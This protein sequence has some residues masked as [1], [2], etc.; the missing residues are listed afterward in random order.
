MIVVH[1]RGDRAATH[2]GA[3]VAALCAMLAAAAAP[4]AAQTDYY[5]TDAGRPVLI[6]DAYPT[7]RYAFDLEVAPLRLE[8]ASGG[9]YL[10]GIEP[11]ITYGVLPRT[12]IE[13]GFPFLAVDALGERRSGLAGIEVG[14]LHN[15]NVETRG[16][17]ALGVRAGLL[18]PVGSL[19]PEE[20]YSSVAGL[21]TRT[22]RW[23][24][25]HVNAEYT[26][27]SEPDAA[28]PAGHDLS[29]WMAG[30][31]V[32]RTF[33]LRSLLVIADLHASQ[34]LH[35]EEDV[36]W[37]AETGMRY[38]HGPRLALDAGVGRRFTGE[39]AWFLTFGTAYQFALRSLIPLPRRGDTGAP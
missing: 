31:A 27:G 23:A 29:R 7:E 6:E 9:A 26:F 20:V 35:Q 11:E 19:A 32:D 10:W 3:P 2:G 12:H 8:R 34:P 22:F 14:A 1:G 25:F 24:R 21:L 4:A 13:I 37:T 5:N 36:Q 16:V 30:V 15:L 33:P 28:G 18:L 39:G 17:P 38:Q